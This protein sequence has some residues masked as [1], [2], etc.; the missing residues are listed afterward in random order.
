MFV[1]ARLGQVLP[2]QGNPQED[3]GGGLQADR[4]AEVPN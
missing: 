3:E 1:S 2:S 4:A